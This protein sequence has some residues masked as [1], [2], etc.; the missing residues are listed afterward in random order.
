MSSG[1]TRIDYKAARLAIRRLD[2]EWSLANKALHY[3]EHER[4]LTS[5]DE[6]RDD[7]LVPE[8]QRIELLE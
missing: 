4:M 8:E 6:G 1:S 7:V 2:S 3:R 5:I